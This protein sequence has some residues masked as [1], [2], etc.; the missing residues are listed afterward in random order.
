MPG[1]RHAAA[2]LQ[3]AMPA[4]FSPSNAAVNAL[5]SA[6]DI[7]A[8]GK[9]RNH[10]AGQVTHLSPYLT[11]GFLT[12]PDLFDK[13]SQLTLADKLAFE[14]GWREFFQHV[15]HR[16]G[17]AIFADMRP[18]LSGIR[19]QQSLPDDIREGRTGLR[20]ID[21]AVK[22]LYQTGYLHNHARMWLASYVVHLRKV[23]WRAAADWLY[24][25]LLDGD[26]AS[27][28]LSWQWV[29][30]T[31]SSKPYLF[32]AENVAKFAPAAW[33]CDGSVLDTSY[34]ALE[35]IART[36]TVMEPAKVKLLFGTAEPAL[37]AMPPTMPATPVIGVAQAIR[38][39]HPWMLADTDFDG[40]RLGIIHLPFHAR[41]PWSQQRWD[42]ML[43]RMRAV[44]DQIF[45]G[46]LTDLRASLATAN[47]V[48]SIATFNP[49]YREL[50]PPLCS[51]LQDAQR[52]FAD[53]VQPCRSFSAFWSASTHAKQD[54]QP[55]AWHR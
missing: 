36:Q 22:T 31:F 1:S 20:V 26:L 25:H 33:H 39:V 51:D 13:L 8:Y 17:D 9:T 37:L 53:P 10:L 49:G 46:D 19:Y 44:T 24:G 42:F 45:I 50:L 15:W 54:A 41:F 5:L 55:R 12:I 16:S 4:N 43:T 2:T 40:L 27:N 30:A 6:I 34:E 3:C 35:Q 18:A 11:H 47:S 29:A 38:L 32:N 21:Q 52:A 23:H 14:F 7:Q 48:Q 28:Y